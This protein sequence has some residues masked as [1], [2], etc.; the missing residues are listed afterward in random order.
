M[1]NDYLQSLPEYKILKQK[2]SLWEKERH[3]WLVKKVGRKMARRLEEIDHMTRR[4]VE[5]DMIYGEQK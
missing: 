2:A 1:S 3:K 5:N 4:Q